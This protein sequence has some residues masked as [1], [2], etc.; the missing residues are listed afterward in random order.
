MMILWMF[1][2]VRMIN[3]NKQMTDWQSTGRERF[4]MHSQRTDNLRPPICLWKKSF[5]QH[6]MSGFIW[7][8]SL[9]QII[10]KKLLRKMIF[11]MTKNRDSDKWKRFDVG[12]SGH[13]ILNFYYKIYFECTWHA[14]INRFRIICCRDVPYFSYDFNFHTNIR[15]QAFG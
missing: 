13:I 15:N 1:R 9:N 2:K 8:S 14:H 6:S 5:S 11:L 7:R 10:G 3:L 4:F 12:I